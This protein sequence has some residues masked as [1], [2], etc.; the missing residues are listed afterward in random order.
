M[1]FNLPAVTT[2]DKFVDGFKAGIF[3]FFFNI[4]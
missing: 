1:F 2:G 4:L 3:N